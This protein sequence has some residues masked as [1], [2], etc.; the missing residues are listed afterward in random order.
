M[1]SYDAIT[2]G[3]LR[4]FIAFLALFPLLVNRIR[5]IPRDKW[6]P[7]LIVCFAGTG[8]PV[9]L[10]A[11][12]QVYLPSAL[13]GILNSTVPLFTLALGILIFGVHLTRNMIFGVLAGFFGVSIILLANSSD[14]IQFD[15]NSVYGLLVL[16]AACCYAV[17][18]N[19]I[20]KYL[21]DVDSVTIASSTFLLLGPLAGIYLFAFSDFLSITTTKP[22]AWKSLLSV[23]IL[24]VVGTFMAKIIFF[25]LVQ[26]TNAV[27]SSMVTYMIPIVALFWGWVDG[28]RL[29]I[30][31][32]IGMSMILFAVY[33]VKRR[34]KHNM[35][36]ANAT[37]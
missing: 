19:T 10:F 28:E 36:L 24:A 21:N 26:R 33:M 29:Q 22:D 2:T 3:S 27:F 7:L 25:G 23:A 11:N 17:S 20:K 4:I 1:I 6:L 15:Q 32:V 34:P 8:F 13:T 14:G 30:I 31:H 9:F 16:L 12:A 5:K 18:M 35:K 37:K